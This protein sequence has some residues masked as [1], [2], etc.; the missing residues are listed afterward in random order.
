MLPRLAMLLFLFVISGCGHVKTAKE[1]YREAVRTYGECEIVSQTESDELTKLV[2]RDELQGFEYT[3][4]S[5]MQDI[6]IDGSSFGS[7]QNT[8][9]TFQTA[10]ADYVFSQCLNDL[11]EIC[12]SAGAV[13]DTDDI[14]FFIVMADNAG[15]AEKAALAC[16]E[17]IQAYNLNGRMDNWAIECYERGTESPY[18]SE[19]FGSVVLPDIEWIS[20]EQEIINYYTEMARMQTDEKAEYLRK[21]EKIFADTG[22]DLDRVVYVLGSD[23]PTE[24]T[25]PVTFYYF[26]AS[27][28]TEYYLCDFNYYAENHYDYAW[29]TNYHDVVPGSGDE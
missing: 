19:R 15:D 6:V 25:S 18:Y 8:G 16:A 1:L 22:A 14:S 7:V 12:E 13:C 3:I 24:N 9:S 28:G 4:S 20:R 29:Y 27:D 21:E 26:R 11:E 23:I 5:G 17:V 2:L 10:L